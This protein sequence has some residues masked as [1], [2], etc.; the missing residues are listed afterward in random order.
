MLNYLNHIRVAVTVGIEKMGIEKMNATLNQ[1][2]TLNS[3]FPNG[4]QGATPGWK[5]KSCC[6]KVYEKTTL[7]LTLFMASAKTFLIS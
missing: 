3:N 5:K 4:Q 6:I 7:L 2:A 1:V